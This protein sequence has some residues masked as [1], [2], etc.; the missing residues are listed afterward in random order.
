MSNPRPGRIFHPTSV[1]MLLSWIA[2]SPSRL[3]WNEIPKVLADLDR[4]Q[5]LKLLLGADRIL[6]L[7]G[8]QIDI[9]LIGHVP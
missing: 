7:N 1:V 2:R 4:D 6:V 5:I 9:N 3:I 8:K